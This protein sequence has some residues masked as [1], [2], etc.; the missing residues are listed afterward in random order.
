MTSTP[1]CAFDAVHAAAYLAALDALRDHG[2]TL[3]PDDETGIRNALISP[4]R[5]AMI[6]D[7]YTHAREQGVKSEAIQVYLAEKYGVSYACVHQVV[8][9]RR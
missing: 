1:P 6:R 9:Y 2:V 4:I 8:I 3:T 5:A 7:E